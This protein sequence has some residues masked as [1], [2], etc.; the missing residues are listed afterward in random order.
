MPQDKSYARELLG[1]SAPT[2]PILGPASRPWR[3]LWGSC[4]EC[5]HHLVIWRNHKTGDY[6]SIHCS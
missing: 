2:I 5:L 1:G 6:R 3:P 4:V